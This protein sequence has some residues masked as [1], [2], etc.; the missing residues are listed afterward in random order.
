[1]PEGHTGYFFLMYISAYIAIG[2]F[3]APYE[4]KVWIQH[5]EFAVE[6][7]YPEC[8]WVHAVCAVYQVQSCVT[9]RALEG[10]KWA[11]NM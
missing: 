11:I 2:P 8:M 4:L 5:F 1:M 6:P 9:T 3:C 10:E 7:C